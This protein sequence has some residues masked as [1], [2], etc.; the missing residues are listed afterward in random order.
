MK[1]VSRIL[2]QLR[3]F[4]LRNGRS[5]RG[6][7]GIH[8]RVFCKIRQN[9]VSFKEKVMNIANRARHTLPVLFDLMALRTWMKKEN[10][11]E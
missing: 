8:N 4:Q 3:P 9:I 11:R 1:E 2:R 6:Y 10:N 7:N 5:L